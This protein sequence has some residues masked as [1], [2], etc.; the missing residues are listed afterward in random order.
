[1]DDVEVTRTA[2]GQ[3]LLTVGRRAMVVSPVELLVLASKTSA[4]VLSRLVGG[5]SE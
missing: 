1:M 3:F 2:D 4:V 5:L